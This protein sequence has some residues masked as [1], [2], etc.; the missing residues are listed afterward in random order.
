M[1]L[2]FAA[3]RASSRWHCL[4]FDGPGQGR[5]LFKQGLFSRPDWENVVRPVIDFAL[6]CR[7]STRSESRS[8]A[9]ALA[10]TLACAGAVDPRLAACVLDPGLIGL[11]Q[12]VRAMLKDLPAA[13]LLT[14]PRGRPRA[15]SRR[16]RTT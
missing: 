4:L 15:V 14:T 12:P 11:K 2:A 10:A 6:S 8:P 7:T 5:P 3:P 1:Y 16:M 9:G 13:A